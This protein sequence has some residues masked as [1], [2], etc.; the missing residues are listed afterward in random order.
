MLKR[1][2]L[3][4]AFLEMLKEIKKKQLEAKAKT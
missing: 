1:E 2:E 3:T 4:V